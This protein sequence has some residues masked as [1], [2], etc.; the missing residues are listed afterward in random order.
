M[1]KSEKMNA[2]FDEI[3]AF[4]A[5][6]EQVIMSL[7]RNQFLENIS[8]LQ[9]RILDELCCFPGIKVSELANH[10]GLSLPNCSRYLNWLI[11]DGYID[12]VNDPLDKRVYF[13]SLSAKGHTLTEAAL[14]KTKEMALTQF[15]R[16][17]EE[18][19]DHIKNAFADIRITLSNH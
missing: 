19:L 18:Q 12:K 14:L 15:E 17:T 1:S 5:F 11:K 10:L 6:Y 8:P 2:L 4:T 13:V 3:N 9:F 7:H 16:L